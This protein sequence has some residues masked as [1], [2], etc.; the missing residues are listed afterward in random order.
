MPNNTNKAL[1]RN[2][3]WVIA[4]FGLLVIMLINMMR[5]APQAK[6]PVKAETPLMEETAPVVSIPSVSDSFEGENST[7]ATTD[8][9]DYFPKE[10]TKEEI[11]PASAS[12]PEA[13]AQT[14]ANTTK[15]SAPAKEQ[16]AAK[17]DKPSQEKEPEDS[18]SEKEK[19]EQKEL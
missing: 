2:V 11:A 14:E 16:P 18:S 8:A 10:S 3:L 15:E 9:P 17:E 19:D 5:P 13:D 7:P 1:S 4:I 12:A 6:P